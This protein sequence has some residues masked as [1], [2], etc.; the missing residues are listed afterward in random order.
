MLQS[1]LDLIARTSQDCAQVV[2]GG[3]GRVT[4]QCVQGGEDIGNAFCATGSLCLSLGELDDVLHAWRNFT[5]GFLD[6]VRTEDIVGGQGA[7]VA[8]A[9]ERDPIRQRRRRFDGAR[10]RRRQWGGGIVGWEEARVEEMHGEV[11]A[12]LL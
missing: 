6:P 2:C 7:Q 3:H 8:D 9:F 11:C 1:R 10:P 12:E 5:P 4:T